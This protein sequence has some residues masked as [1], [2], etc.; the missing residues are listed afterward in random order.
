MSKRSKRMQSLTSQLQRSMA[1][2]G[3]VEDMIAAE[4]SAVSAKLTE[5]LEAERERSDDLSSLLKQV[6]NSSFWY[7]IILFGILFY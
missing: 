6:K 1:R 7:R 5:E 4:L 3:E 2:K